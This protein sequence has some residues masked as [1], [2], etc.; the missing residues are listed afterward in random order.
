MTE[1][2]SPENLRKFL[3]SDDPALVRMGLSMAK[4][5][6][7]HE[8]L[9]PIILR[10][11]MWGDDKTVR[12]V[13]KS[14][15]NKYA[16][17]EIQAKVKE[18]WK[19]SY[20]TLSIAG[21]KFLEVIRS[22]VDIFSYQDDIVNVLFYP[23]FQALRDG[24]GSAANALEMIGDAN[25]KAIDPLVDIYNAEKQWTILHALEKIGKK[26]DMN[27]GELDLWIEVCPRCEDW[28][29]S[30]EWDSPVDEPYCEGCIEG[31]D[32]KLGRGNY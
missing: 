19:A 22:L 7:V 29:D 30:N 26:H 25:K 10:L 9:L 23:L 17:E 28:Y 2:T 16:S 3:E 31:L 32:Y 12:A 11:Y 13:A 8:E 4:G 20:R 27:P 14:F 5:M 1:D 21:D 15:F 18:N 24:N 6:G